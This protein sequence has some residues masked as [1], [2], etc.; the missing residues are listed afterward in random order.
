MNEVR[1]RAES[2]WEIAIRHGFRRGDMPV[3][4]P[5]WDATVSCRAQMRS[6]YPDTLPLEFERACQ[7]PGAP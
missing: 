5:V 7:A 1:T 4:G 2:V 6:M 3:S